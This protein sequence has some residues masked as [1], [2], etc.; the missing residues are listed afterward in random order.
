MRT[1][2]ARA[3]WFSW[4][5]GA[6]THRKL[7]P[8]LSSACTGREMQAASNAARRVLHSEQSA[9]A[10]AVDTAPQA[11][12]LQREVYQCNANVARAAVRACLAGRRGEPWRLRVCS[13]TWASGDLSSS[14]AALSVGRNMCASAASGCLL[15]ACNGTTNCSPSA[16]A[17]SPAARQSPAPPWHGR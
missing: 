5:L 10:E 3:M 13:A 2:V 15:T 12:G 6:L 14:L 11:P 9:H 1:P 7:C 8:Y 4:E 16:A 17:R